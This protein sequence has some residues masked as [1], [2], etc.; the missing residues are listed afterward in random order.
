MTDRE[1][2]LR[3]MRY[4]DVDR[5]PY[6]EMGPWPETRQRWE[7]EIPLCKDTPVPT[8]KHQWI[9]SWFFPN[10]PFE[11]KVISEDE[12][13]IT[14]VNHEG[15]V[16]KERKDNPYSSMPQFVKFPVETPAEFR[17]FWKERMNP[18]MVARLGADW[19]A[20]LEGLRNRDYPIALIADR[21][22]GFF[23]SLRNL[24]GVENLCMTFYD[25]PAFV[26]EMM[27]CVADFMIAVMDQVLDH[28]EVDTFG[29]WEDM[30]YKTAPLIS[31][32]MVRKYM[33]PRYRRVCDFLYKRGVEFISLDSDGDMASLISIW[34]DAGIN[35]LYPFEVQCGMDVNKVRKEY[36]KD[37]RIWYG[38]DKRAIAAGPNAIDIEVKR[39]APLI[40]DGGYLPGPDHSYPPDISY[41][42][43]V[44]FTKKL[45][46]AL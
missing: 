34:M 43:Y 44:Y 29:F 32:A 35:V 23:G 33:F 11:H 28:M 6:W 12:R 3:T 9:S 41:E 19:I 46:E 22:G 40:R 5:V 2:F 42:N 45:F 39:V 7:T 30:A 8:D 13:T 21:W 26:E 31:P 27:D 36:G 10:P 24:M 37:L 14:Y 17:T 20:K 38:M 15:I 16:I 4:Q 25:D 1:R 18:D